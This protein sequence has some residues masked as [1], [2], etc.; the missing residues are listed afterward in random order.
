MRSA[1]RA[2]SAVADEADHPRAVSNA[3]QTGAERVSAGQGELPE[4]L[5][6]LADLIAASPHNLVSR[7]ER[8]T[9]LER[10]VVEC[11]ALA[12]T[13]APSG[14][15]M[16]LGTGGGLPGLVLAWRHPAVSWTLVDAT[17]KKVTAVAAF[18]AELGLRNV[19]AVHGRAEQLGVDP[20]HRGRYDGVVT[21][22]VA[23]LR[24]LAELCRGFVGDGGRIV[25]M[26]GPAVSDELDAAGNALA[27]LRLRVLS[28]DRLNVADR[29]SWVVTM[30]AD[31]PPPPGFP[32]RDGVPKFEPL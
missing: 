19:E 7:G 17:A 25:A 4:P 10:H 1:E 9:V 12:M 31:G 18:A 21:R 13:L 20:A 14:R 30:A 24:T 11:D 23:P 27:R 8:A 26:K 3:P 15:W 22:A 28:A 32:R 5:R 6:R 2:I 29:D 16:D